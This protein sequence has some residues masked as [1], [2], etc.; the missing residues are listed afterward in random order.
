MFFRHLYSLNLVNNNGQTTKKLYCIPEGLEHFMLSKDYKQ[1]S[2]FLTHWATDRKKEL[3]K[4]LGKNKG[5]FT[6][7]CWDIETGNMIA[8]SDYMVVN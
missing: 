5:I 6:L 2:L 8:G 1:D 4:L 7:C 3:I